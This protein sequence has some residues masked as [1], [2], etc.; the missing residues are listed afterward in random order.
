M[1]WPALGKKYHKRGRGTKKTPVV[2]IKER[3]SGRVHAQVM[4]ANEE[5]K[6]LTGKQLLAVLDK[7]CKKGT[8]LRNC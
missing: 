1:P 5:S 4:L 6:K 2:G 8:T 3:G 7:V